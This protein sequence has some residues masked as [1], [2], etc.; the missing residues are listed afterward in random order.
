MRCDAPRAD[1]VLSAGG[2]KDL[3]VFEQIVGAS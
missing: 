2:A 1:L 3:P